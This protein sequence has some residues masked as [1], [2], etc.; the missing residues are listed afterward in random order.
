MPSSLPIYLRTYRKKSGL[1]QRELAFLLGAESGSK[2]SRYERLARV[3]SL[4]AA[5]GLH[6][7]FGASPDRIFSGLFAEVEQSITERARLLESELTQGSADAFLEQKLM[8]L[9]TI[10]RPPPA[11]THTFHENHTSNRTD[12]HGG[13]PN[14]ERTGLRGL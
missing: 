8:L 11:G 5:F 13:L 12:R 14:D 4:Q 6:V 3:P 10:G 1:T 2:I 9:R 7:V